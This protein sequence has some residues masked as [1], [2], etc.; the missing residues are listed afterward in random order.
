MWCTD[1]QKKKEMTG[2]NNGDHMTR[3]SLD[4]Q[5]RKNEETVDRL[6]REREKEKKS[7]INARRSIAK[8]H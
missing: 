5:K 7:G 8:L 2:C 3:V 6:S 4:C 1:T